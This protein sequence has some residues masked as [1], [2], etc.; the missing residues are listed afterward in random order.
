MLN[1][2]LVLCGRLGLGLIE[3]V[4]GCVEDWGEGWGLLDVF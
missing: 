2:L 4:G 3:F 1:W